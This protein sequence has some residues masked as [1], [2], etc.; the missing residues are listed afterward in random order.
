MSGRYQHQRGLV[1]F[2][3]DLRVHDN[4]A[5]YRAV[6][7]CHEVA[8][9]F[10]ACPQTW[11][12]HDEGDNLVAFRLA[13][14]RELQAALGERNIPL[15]FLELKRFEQV[16]QAM[17]QIVSKLQASAVYA[18][19]EYP[20]NERRRDQSVRQ[21]LR[22]M[23]VA[24]EFTSDRTL[25]PPGAIKTNSGEA[26]KVFTPFKRA[27]IAQCG[28]AD[29]S[30][31][32]A[33]RKRAAADWPGWLQIEGK[34]NLRQTIPATVKG[35]RAMPLEQGRLLGWQPGEKAARKRLKGFEERI[36][37][38][39]DERDFP[40]IDG[41]SKLSPYLSS[42]ALSVRQC[43]QLALACNRGR[44]TGGRAGVDC[45]LG[46]LIWRE[47]YTH[48]LVAFPRLCKHQPFKLETEGVRWSAD[49]QAFRRWCRGETGV[50]IVDAAMLQ[51]QQSGWMH[52]RLRMVVASFLTK[53][54]LI[55]WRWGER[56]FMN[57]LIDG[58]FAANNGGWQWAA[59][60]GTDAAPYFR[61]FN[62]YS[63]SEK[64]DRRGEF[65]RHY[66]PALQKLSDKQVHQPPPM[67]G[68]P[69]PICD[70][71]ETRKRAIEAF[72]ALKK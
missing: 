29:F 72:A 34:D 43:A 52:N 14:L 8:G 71:K 69:A 1:W 31:L 12:S 42:G 20:L 44:W 27:F 13:C 6:E 64:F 51:L 28:G 47:F 61:V 35:Y 48:L 19:A 65:I 26:Y 5:L 55:D 45:W 50:P 57:L 54:L 2:R 41:T 68:Y 62:P 49:E 7:S 58:D 66:L 3:S 56:Y 24:I 53:N 40:G 59:S 63:Q 30:P 46:E 38:Y 21:A 17:A 10:I 60:T 36:H 67:A 25:V 18:N 15:Y 23:E 39:A 4:M 32:P 16:P 9:V 22:E 33:P 37:A 70:V 11:Q